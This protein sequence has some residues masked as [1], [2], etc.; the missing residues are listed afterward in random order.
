M[1]FKPTQEQ[2]DAIH[3]RG[4]E[5][6]VS[7]A[8]GSGKTKVLVERLMS[9]ITDQGAEIDDFLV[10]TFTRAAA[11]ELRIRI[12]DGLQALLEEDPGNRSLRRQTTLVYGAQ[13]STVHGFC[14]SFLRE[15]ACQLDLPPDFRILEDTEEKLL[16]R[17]VL[18]EVLEARYEAMT[19]AFARLSDDLSFGQRDDSRV[20]ELTLELYEKLRSQPDP[21]AW[22][23][24]QRQRLRMEGLT[25]AGQTPW[26]R[27]LLEQA[28]R[29]AAWCRRELEQGLADMAGDEMLM[30][31]Y[32]PAFQ[33]AVRS[34]TQFEAACADGWDA[35]LAALPIQFLNLKGQGKFEDPALRARMKGLW[36]RSKDRFQA[37]PGL[38]FCTSAEAAEDLADV[39]PVMEALFDLVEDFTAACMAEKRRR[40]G[41]DFSDLEHLTLRALTERPELAAA[42][43]AR[44]REVLV[45][46]YQDTN[47]V[48]DA[49]FRAVSD[50]GRK[51]FCVGDVKQSIYRF[52]LADPTIFLEKYRRFPPSAQAAE[53]EPRRLIL[54]RN[55]RSRPG[56]LAAC[57]FV[58]SNIMSREMGEV[59]YT[60]DQRLQY[61]PGRDD[62]TDPGHVELVLLDL[63]EETPA[64]EKT[65]WRLREAR[66]IAAAIRQ[67]LDEEQ[68][69]LDPDSGQKR[70]V[71]PEDIAILMRDVAG[72]A[73]GYFTRALQA[74]GI[75]CHTS[76][77]TGFFEALEI[78]QLLSLLAVVDNPRQDVALLAVLRS[79]LFG[80]SGDRLAELRLLDGDAGFYDLLRLAAERGEEDCRRVLETVETLRECAVDDTVEQLLRRACGLL[81][82]PSV[83]RAL[84]GGED[85]GANLD[86]LLDYARRFEDT[87]RRSL[88]DFLRHMEGLQEAGQAPKLPGRGGGEGVTVMTIHGAKGLEYPVV[89]L[90]SLAKSFNLDDLRK[91]LLIHPAL[92]VG[93]RRL[94]RERRLQYPT[95]PRAAVARQLEMER[96]AEE[97]RLL[98]VAMTRARDRLIM[99]CS[100]DKPAG[101][102][103]KLGEVWSAPADPV[104]IES[105]SCMGKWLLLAALGR[106]EALP[107][108]LE[109]DWQNDALLPLPDGYPWT[110]TMARPPEE[111]RMKQTASGAA[112]SQ[113]EVSP[114]EIERLRRELFAAYPHEA[115]TQLPS[116]LTATG[117]KGRALDREAAADA[118]TPSPALTFRRPQFAADARGLTA[119]QRG[120]AHHLAMQYLDFSRTDTVQKI[121]E[122]LR[123]LAQEQ[124]L[125]EEQARAVDAEKLLTFFRSP[126]GRR[127][128][129]AEGLQREFKFS[130]LLPAALYDPEAG[131]DEILLQG[132]VDCFWPE[133]G[134]LTVLDFKTDRIAPGGEAER[135]ESYRTQLDAYARALTEV[136][137][138]PVRRRLLWFFATGTLY[139]LTE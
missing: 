131:E 4:G 70:P 34:L 61:G 23:A 126:L 82:A 39:A 9:W 113:P 1:K 73:R 77:E 35:A 117:L 37:L 65:N 83:F 20:E 8:A 91:E 22:M 121:R 106:P 128:R 81:D 103:K 56:I 122:Q 47:G 27:L 86:A 48:Q 41:L 59:D 109:A 72:G 2:Y 139:E 5:T 31:N 74:H 52:R 46:E 105:Q 66:Y 84:R 17:S 36:S 69:I 49:I 43:A 114:E 14:T 124:F 16:R 100:F 53:G 136:F 45:D 63:T 54:S 108:R 88:F 137:G 80:F 7:A 92:G 118:P 58:F 51:L 104:V 96:K 132:V 94:E 55:F 76:G 71:R 68:M 75:P 102:L 89:F 127:L 26:G 87:G 111:G 107:L 90:A 138:L 123:R 42:C 6:L 79:P 32:A 12:V 85:R 119:A 33:T 98:Y 134:G 19:P 97:M 44:Y 116:K 64:D 13:I 24:E 93:P 50:G 40:K 67:M 130:V 57:N 60:E 11:A 125:S 101:V 21:S 99:L 120:S 110:I 18:K 3:D 30:K 38:L 62:G 28:A 129:E 15:N 133:D 115:A 78:S 135:A 95:L 112:A 10:I 29:S 25:D